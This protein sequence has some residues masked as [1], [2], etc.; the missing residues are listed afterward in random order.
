MKKLVIFVVVFGFLGIGNVYAQEFTLKSD[1][2]SGQLT[3]TQVFFG[4]WLYWK[5]HFTI[6]E[7][8]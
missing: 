7:M 1:D 6:S 8:D 5:K 4:I 2:L 3:E